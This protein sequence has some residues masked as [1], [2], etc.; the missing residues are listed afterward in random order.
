MKSLNYYGVRNGA[1]HQV[2]VRVETQRRMFMTQILTVELPELSLI[3][4]SLYFSPQRLLIIVITRSLLAS[5]VLFINVQQHCEQTPAV[6]N[7]HFA[8]CS[9]L[10]TSVQR[11]WTH[12]TDST[13]FTRVERRHGIEVVES[14]LLKIS[15]YPK[16]SPS[17][18]E[19][20]VF[21]LVTEILMLCLDLNLT[22]PLTSVNFLNFF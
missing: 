22:P 10:T 7:T 15:L 3:V 9:S 14:R 2:D 19:Y 8:H 1:A 13:F 12:D 11:I 17:A 16:C 21:K 4:Q 5:R 18:K 20:L 6:I